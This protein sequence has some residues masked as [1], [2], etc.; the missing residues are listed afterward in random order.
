MATRD[1][2]RDRPSVA[3]PTIR[4]A[5][6]RIG[7]CATSR[8]IRSPTSTAGRR[9]TAPGSSRPPS[10]RASGRPT[11]SRRAAWDRQVSARH[12]TN[13]AASSKASRWRVP[14][15]GCWAAATAG[16]SSRPL[17]SASTSFDAD[18]GAAQARAAQLRDEISCADE[19]ATQAL[20]QW[21]ADRRRDEDR[22]VS[23]RAALQDELRATELE[24]EA[25]RRGVRHV[26]A[27]RVAV[28]RAT[29]A[30][31]LRDAQ[32]LVETRRAAAER[33]V[34]ELRRAR[35]VLVE[36]A[37]LQRWAARFPDADVAVPWAT[38][39]L[40]SKRTHVALGLPASTGIEALL[41]ALTTDIET[42]ATAA[43]AGTAETIESP[44]GGA[45]GRRAPTS[46][47]PSAPPAASSD[48]TRRPRR[49][50]TACR[51]N[52]SPRRSTTRSCARSPRTRGW[53][54]DRGTARTA[55]RRCHRLRAGHRRR[56]G[57]RRDGAPSA[58][59]RARRSAQIAGDSR[60]GSRMPARQYRPTLSASP[61]STQRR[62]R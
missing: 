60:R 14:R 49:R 30:E 9:R 22:P 31:M 6:W 35:D 54:H 38:L 26:E 10:V 21:L 29:A 42:I 55:N 34:D 1:E 57:R 15:R 46:T 48:A 40:A 13:S 17:T 18:V 45:L 4:R 28:R 62:T 36:A 25:V 44:T 11:G 51:A 3:R 5:C 47:R 41:D 7:A 20:E 32:R 58:I 52:R 2:D 23:L 56:Q 43:S 50:L 27:E 8:S 37:G 39:A 16:R 61:I 12:S 19:D 53:R 33:L 24:I 59:R